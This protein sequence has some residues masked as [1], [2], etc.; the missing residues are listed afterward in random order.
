MEHVQKDH[1]LGQERDFDGEDVCSEVF[2]SREPGGG[3]LVAHCGEE[4]A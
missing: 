2:A 3:K 1:W 4:A